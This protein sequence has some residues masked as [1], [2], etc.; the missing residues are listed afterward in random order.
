MDYHNPSTFEEASAIAANAGGT[1]KF[2]AGGT[3]L[4][5]QLRSGIVNLDT[6]IDLKNIPAAKKIK[7]EPD[8]S[9]TV[10]VAVSG[11]EMSEHTEIGREWPGLI[12]AVDLIGSTQ[13]QG[14]ATMVGNLCNGSPAADCVP[15]LF[16][17][18]AEV[19][20]TGTSGVRRVKVED[21]PAGPGKTSLKM[22]EV[23]SALHIPAR[24]PGGGD[25]YLRFIPRTEMDIAVV[26]CAVN[27]RVKD[28][29]I[30]E[31][32]VAL[33]AVAPT[34]LLFEKSNAVLIG[35][36]LNDDVLEMLAAETSASCNPINDKRGTIEFRKEVAGVLVKRAAKIA[37]HRAGR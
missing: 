16:A 15:A 12:E 5:V 28:T 22:Y 27:L 3:D 35:S 10:G 2:L 25:S 21:I 4:L 18:G 9:W 29:I 31:A 32:R 6:V 17:A 8:D 26:G 1:T 36:P 11:A 24:K 7:R 30:T 19:S 14:R 34:V 23:I 20:I 13:I 37:Y 33:G